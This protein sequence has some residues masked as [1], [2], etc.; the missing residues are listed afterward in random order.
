M[1]ATS[2][3]V[4]TEDDIILHII[5]LISILVTTLISCLIELQKP[6]QKRSATP[7]SQDKK[8]NNNSKQTSPTS[9]EKPT[10]ICRAP[11]G[12]LQISPQRRCLHRQAQQK[13]V[14]LEALAKPRGEP[15]R[16]VRNPEQRRHRRMGLRQLLLHAGG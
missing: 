16:L 14:L 8:P 6:S 7:R 11:A 3:T 2:T 5:V 10:D 12:A 15:R 4:S 13:V 9:L 1:T